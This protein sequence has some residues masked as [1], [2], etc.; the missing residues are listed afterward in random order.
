MAQDNPKDFKA[1]IV[2]YKVNLL[3]WTMLGQKMFA[4]MM[5][6]EQSALNAEG[7]F[8]FIKLK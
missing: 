7:S 2:A 4:F 6:M 1:G 8:M 5:N 3:L